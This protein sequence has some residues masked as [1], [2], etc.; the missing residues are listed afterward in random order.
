MSSR[1]QR[2]HP[3]ARQDGT[4]EGMRGIGEVCRLTRAKSV[5]PRV[6]PLPVCLASRAAAAPHSASW[7]RSGQLTAVGGLQH[8]E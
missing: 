7:H 3:P 4:L 6:R 2:I 5:S 1:T 8:V